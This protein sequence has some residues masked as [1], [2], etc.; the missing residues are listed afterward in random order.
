VFV[1]W[2]IRVIKPPSETLKTKEEMNTLEINRTTEFVDSLNSADRQMVED[3]IGLN[4]Q[5]AE[6][7]LDLVEWSKD[8]YRLGTMIAHLFSGDDGA[9][10][11]GDALDA[12]RGTLNRRRLEQA[13]R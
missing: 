13:T 2:S 12:I 1:F 9:G 6:E 8:C 3:M 4:E 10:P 11:S 7:W 5:P